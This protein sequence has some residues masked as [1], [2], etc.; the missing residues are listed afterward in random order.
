MRERK[1][2]L[3]VYL[4]V[5]SEGAGVCV[6]LVTHF[7]EVWLVRCVDMHVFLAVTAVCKS[8]VAAFKLTLKGL[9]TYMKNK[10]TFKM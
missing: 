10:V 3:I 4:H 7:A 1:K 9:L 2:A 5:F 8:P 6:G